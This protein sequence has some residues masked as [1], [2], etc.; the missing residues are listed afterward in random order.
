M[1]YKVTHLKN[2]VITVLFSFSVL[3][4]YTSPITSQ[5]S[6]LIGKECTK[7]IDSLK[8]RLKAI[9][10]L[11]LISTGTMNLSE[12]SYINAPSDRP[13][14]LL[15]VMADSGGKNLMHSSKMM[16]SISTNIIA[17]CKSIGA[18]SFGINQTDWGAIY[19]L[20]PNGATQAFQCV[21]PHRGESHN[22]LKWGTYLCL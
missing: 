3:S 18:V 14:I 1:Q 2:I 15:I 21:E 9:K 5:P 11:N 8:S 7:S 16:K 4:G 13:L 22:D 12:W 20:M 6:S 10:K 19:G 17:S